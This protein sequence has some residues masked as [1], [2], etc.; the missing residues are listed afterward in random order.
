VIDGLQGA[1]VTGQGVADNWG[2][3]AALVAWAAFGIYAS[4]RWFRWE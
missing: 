2:A 1:I 3:V 4:V